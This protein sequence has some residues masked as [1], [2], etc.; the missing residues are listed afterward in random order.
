MTSQI[1]QS[2]ATT[3][4]N[5]GGDGIASDKLFMRNKIEPPFL[6][7][8]HDLMRW[9]SSQRVRGVIVGGIA[10]SFLGRPRTTL[11]IDVLILL[12]AEKWQGFLENAEHYGFMPRIKNALA[13]AKESRVFLL[14][15]ESTNISLD[16]SLGM[17]PFEE[18][19]IQRARAKNIMGIRVPLPTPEDLIVMKSIAHRP[20][21]IADI[22]SILEANPRCDLKRVRRW[23]RAFST[24][25]E[26]PE[27]LEDLEKTIKHVKNIR[28]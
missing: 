19:L 11:D 23:V 8:I 17:L 14:R 24:A 3:R 12:P 16:I 13:F 5:P 20:R 28:S 7:A 9:L 6:S 26:M 15:H 10:A 2:H 1:G 25:L 27:L 22:E 18:E 21:D 4:K